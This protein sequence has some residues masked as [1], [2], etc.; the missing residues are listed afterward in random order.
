[1][2]LKK[3]I[4]MFEQFLEHQGLQYDITRGAGLSRAYVFDT[5]ESAF[6]SFCAGY[7]LAK[8][9]GKAKARELKNEITELAYLLEQRPAQGVDPE[10][11][12]QGFNLKPNPLF[13][14]LVGVLPQGTA[15]INASEVD[16]VKGDFVSALALKPK[17]ANLRKVEHN[18][19]VRRIDA[20][21]GRIWIDI[22]GGP[23]CHPYDFSCLLS[24]I[25]VWRGLILVHPDIPVED[26]WPCTGDVCSAVMGH[27]G[28][29]VSCCVL[30]FSPKNH[31]VEVT[32]DGGPEGHKVMLSTDKIVKINGRTVVQPEV[33]VTVMPVSEFHPKMNDEVQTLPLNLTGSI[34]PPTAT[35]FKGSV[36]S[37]D[38][39]K[40]TIEVQVD[41]G[42][43]IIIEATGVDIWN[44]KKVRI[45]R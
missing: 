43:R 14:G 30:T 17:S 32:V 35:F 45:I 41:R 36:V 24:D 33:E 19:R 27:G 39:S 23:A 20:E 37:Y 2:K 10:P 42:M 26:L 21:T 4:Q 44:G 31:T 9:K 40:H 29:P 1:M 18:G 6:I 11:E 38:E 34:L 8:K 13:T 16:L 28:E 12:P 7:E 15:Y 5:T 25:T 3:L 22:N